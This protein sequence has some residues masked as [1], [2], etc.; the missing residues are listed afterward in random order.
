MAPIGGGPPVGSTGGTFTGP[1]QALEII[2]DHCMAYSG[3]FTA[4]TSSQTMLSF[5]S[6]NYYADATLQCNGPINI[7]NIG[8]GALTAFVVTFNGAVVANLKVTGSD[9]TSPYSETQQLI[10]PPYTEVEVSC[11]SSGTSAGFES[12]ASITGRIYR[13]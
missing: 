9:E 12:T 6:G 8:G 10:I 7:T 3:Q 11:I 13:G 1:A 2:G 4:N 5:T